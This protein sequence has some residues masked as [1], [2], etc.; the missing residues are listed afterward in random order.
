[1]VKF[2]HVGNTVSVQHMTGS[3]L[4]ISYS[5]IF[6]QPA[7]LFSVQIN[8]IFKLGSCHILYSAFSTVV[9]VLCIYVNTEQVAL[10]HTSVT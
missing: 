10:R 6:T 8:F 4:F 2:Q 9:T 1:M 7:L 5:P 3:S